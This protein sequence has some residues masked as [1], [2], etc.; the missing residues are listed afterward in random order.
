MKKSSSYEVNS[1]LSISEAMRKMDSLKTKLLIVT[2]D[3]KKYRGLISIGDI[4][5]GILNGISLDSEIRNVLRKENIIASPFDTIETIKKIMLAIRAE[6]M[7]IVNDQREIVDI[8]FWED[9]FE[10]ENQIPIDQFNLPVVIMAGGL[11]TRL[12]PLTNVLPKPLIPIGEKTMLEEIFDRFTKHGCNQFFI[13][14]NY[15]ADLIKYYLSSLNLQFQAECFVEEKPLGTAGSLHLLNGRIDKTFFVS[16]C[17]I[18]IDD[19]YAK[20]LDYHYQNKN[21][22]TVISAF[23][24]FSIPYGTLKSGKNGNLLSIEEKPDLNFNINTGMYV[25]E[26]HLLK[27]I[28]ENEFF[29]ITHLI[30][31]VL[32][33]KGKLGVFPVSEKSWKDIGDWNEYVKNRII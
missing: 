31:K 7:P 10:K 18:L 20:I 15:K 33:R 29:H 27:E 21:E 5:R 19:D 32:K 30:S 17:D 26:P 2:D 12:K 4:Q 16:N 28:P 25:L 24:Q 14:V 6:F 23:K 8:V 3:T 1:K 11:G 9:I 22:I 13:S